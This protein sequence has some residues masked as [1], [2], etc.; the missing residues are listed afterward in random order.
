MNKNT[1]CNIC[2]GLGYTRSKL[3]LKT[4][5]PKKW[6]S[7]KNIRQKY[8]DCSLIVNYTIDISTHEEIIWVK[9]RFQS[10]LHKQTW[11]IPKPP[12]NYLPK[13]DDIFEPYLTLFEIYP[14]NNVYRRVYEKQLNIEA[15]PF[16]ARLTSYWLDHNTDEKEVA[17]FIIT[18]AKQ[19]ER[20]KK[21]N[22]LGI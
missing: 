11:N 17:N 2:S 5:K 6:C 7:C 15:N 1:K 21:L 18:K 22:E 4:I 9:N 16:W 10:E 3:S 19:I 13:P 14:D 8:P 12:L 20:E